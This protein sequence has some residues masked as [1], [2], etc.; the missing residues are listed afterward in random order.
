MNKNVYAWVS[1]NEVVVCSE[2]MAAKK[3]SFD[4]TYYSN[5]EEYVAAVIYGS[6]GSVENETVALNL[7]LCNSYFH[8]GN[9]FLSKVRT[10]KDEH[11][12]YRNYSMPVS[13]D[14]DSDNT[15]YFEQ[16]TDF[17]YDG[18]SLDRL[19]DIPLLQKY[20]K[21]KSF[22]SW[23]SK[24]VE[25]LLSQISKYGI[26]VDSIV[27]DIYFLNTAAKKYSDSN[28]VV[29]FS[30]SHSEIAIFEGGR[31]KNI[32]KYNFGVGN[33]VSH[34]SN[35]FGV[36]YR[37]ASVLVAMY[38]FASVPSRYVHYEISIPI[39]NEITKIV[40]ITDI[41]YEIQ[42]V[43]KKQFVQLCSELKKYGVEN[44]VLSGMPVV[45]ANVLMQ[46]IS[47]CD[48]NYVGDFSFGMMKEA[49]AVLRTN[50]YSVTMESECVE[51]KEKVVEPDKF[52]SASDNSGRF[53]DLKSRFNCLF[54]KI[55][56]SKVRIEAMMTEAE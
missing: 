8:L 33:L 44:I 46:M 40:K 4:Y 37:N 10:K 55:K 41:S 13:T 1:K 7:V 32:L 54:E 51:D 3:V 50:S 39:Y 20:I 56:E 12:K 43:L 34:I 35:I 16:H 6:I 49:F 45:D 9:Q 23:D 14:F 29:T 26:S 53:V 52:P 2:S 11:Y 42:S 21:R 27:P 36:S 47:E 25:A 15:L 38:G 22:M 30:E 18:K 5:F 48:C 19:E 31:V 24:R 17:E 28:A